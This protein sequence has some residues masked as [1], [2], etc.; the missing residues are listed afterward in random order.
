MRE[1]GHEAS[2]VGVAGLYAELAASLV[3]DDADAADADAVTA[4][5]PR[6]VVAPAV[7]HG[8]EEAAALARAT[9]AAVA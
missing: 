8:P 4:A 6:A 3:I 9:L 1:L 2:V 7:M 5:G